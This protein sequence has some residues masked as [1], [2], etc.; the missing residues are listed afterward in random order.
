MYAEE[1]SSEVKLFG[2]LCSNLRSNI[3]PER[4]G[5]PPSNLT[6]S[7]SSTLYPFSNKKKMRKNSELWIGQCN[8]SLTLF[9]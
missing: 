7:A 5:V 2:E 8:F 1:L 6:M 3:Q 9:T 4:D